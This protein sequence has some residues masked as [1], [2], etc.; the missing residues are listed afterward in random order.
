[1]QKLKS[2]SIPKTVKSV[3]SYSFYNTAIEN[4]TIPKSVKTIGA[5]SLCNCKLLTTVTMP[6][7]LR[8]TLQTEKMKI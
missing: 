5:G 8:F 4:I 2:V 7:N 6:G 1:M 3:G